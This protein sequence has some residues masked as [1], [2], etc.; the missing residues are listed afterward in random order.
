MRTYNNN[1][2]P[3]R[4]WKER[5]KE[6]EFSMTVL[7]V[8]GNPVETKSTTPEGIMDVLMGKEKKITRDADELK[9][10]PTLDLD[11]IARRTV[12]TGFMGIMREASPAAV[13]F[14]PFIKRS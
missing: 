11:G 2:K 13:H 1:Y 5:P 12:N 10:K 3:R 7:D 14:I 4:Q 9:P 8:A 6:G